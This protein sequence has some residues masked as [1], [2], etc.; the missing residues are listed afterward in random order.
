MD[1]YTLDLCKELPFYYCSPFSI[2]QLTQS[3]KSKVLE[4]LEAN[5]FSK[6]MRKLV[7]GVSKDNY[8]CS[9]YMEDSINNLSRKHKTDCLKNFH[10]NVESFNTNGAKVAAYLKCFNFKYDIICLTEIRVYNPSIIQM[11]FPDYHVYLDCKSSKK[12]G[13]AILL[14]RN[15]FNSINEIDLNDNFNIKNHCTCKNCKTENRWLSIKINNL[16]VIVGG[17]YRHPKGNI[18]HFNSALNNIISQISDNTL[19][20]VLG[21]ININLLSENNVKINEYLNNFLTSNFIPCITLPTRIRNHS[22]SLIDHIFIKNPRKLIQNKC[23]SGNLITDISDHLAN[24]SFLDIKTPS[25]NDRP[26]IRLF[27]DKRIKSFK[28]NLNSEVSL[29]ENCDFL[30]INTT[31]DMFS[32]N[33]IKLFNKYFPYVKQ[34]RK[35]FRDKPYITSGIKVSIK[36]KH[37]LYHK[38]LNNPNDITEAAW[39]RYRNLTNSIIKK[40]QEMYYKKM[41]DSHNNSSKNLWKTFGTI[42]NK[43]KQTHRKINE[44]KIGESIINEPKKI[45]ESFNQ[46]FSEIGMKLANKFQN[47]NTNEYKKYLDNPAEQSLLLYRISYIE[48]K[49]AISNLKNSNSSSHDEITSKF[50]KISSP[51]LIPALEKVFNLSITSGIYPSNL[52]VSK[53]I[54]IYKKGDSKSI[55]NYRPISILSTINKIFEKILHTRLTKYIEEFNLLYKYQFGFRKNHSTEHALVEIVDQIRFSIDNS[56]LTCGIFIDLSKAFDTVNHDILLGKLEHYGIRGNA[57]NLFKSYLSNRKQYTVIENNKS[58]ICNIECGVPQGSVLGPLFFILFIND[59]PNC[60]PLGKVRIFADDT[61]VFF[62]CNDVKVLVSTAKIIM[63]Q[64]NSWFDINKL[65]LNTTKT[66]F[67]IFKSNR[68]KIENIPNKIDFAN[69]TI[70]RTTTIKFLGI[71]LD[72]H[73]TWNQHIIE[74]CNKLKS[75]FHIF[76][77]IRRYLSKENIK[78][79]YYTLIYSRIKYGLIV[80]GQASIT[81]LNKIQT[82]QNRLLKILSS[83]KFRYST[84]RLHDEFEIL[85][86]KDMVKQ[87]VLTFVFNYFNNNLPDVFN[88]YYET[89]AS[90]HGLNTRYGSF[91]IRKIKHKTKIGAHTIKIQGPDL[92][93]KLDNQLKSI[94]HV[95]MFRNKYKHSIIPY[96]PN[97]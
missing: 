51:L 24:F 78:T 34:S 44:I 70:E 83:K 88:N 23:S 62:H 91:L 95:K 53:V 30:E 49:E 12:G 69:Y 1:N 48:I 94:L 71:I 36:Y 16:N 76:Y 82:L 5:N 38:Y 58:Q 31:Y 86:V 57:L 21:D 81:K 2:S 87:E 35:S 43:N 77:N 26:Y 47:N 67:T 14:K 45:A 72:E 52:K 32:D 93:N 74:V 96:I 66:S 15:K 68:K 29:V 11:E 65:T 60:C 3:S 80:Y 40:S 73:L 28:E 6:N 9:Y 59:L 55:N 56:Q 33:Y 20:I 19:A 46:F 27:T 10:Y 84:D 25:I 13:V 41:I 61:N 8:T 97:I 50:V 79:L 42:I 18:N 63:T 37:K 39:K 92:W 54:P 17:V 90:G 64:L 75:L 22:I 4:K 89:L 85:K 7:N